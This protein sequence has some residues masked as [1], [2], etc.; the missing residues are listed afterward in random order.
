MKMS[1]GTRVLLTVFLVLVII[2]SAILLLAT[3][4]YECQVILSDFINTILHGDVGYKIL[5]VVLFAVVIIV[6]VRLIFFGTLRASENTVKIAQFDCGTIEITVKAI[7]ELVEKFVKEAKS[8]KGIKSKVLAYGSF[9]NIFVEITVLP[10]S[11]I[12]EITKAL[13][14]NL[15]EYIT[16]HT[17]LYVKETKITVLATSDKVNALI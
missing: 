4:N 12:P 14:T 16:K 11:D 15:A 7:E 3:F 6:C 13:Q 8:V 2:A 9:I 5:N 17:G 10:D 1:T